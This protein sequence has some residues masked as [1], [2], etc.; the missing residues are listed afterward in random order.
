[1]TFTG[2]IKMA[3]GRIRSEERKGRKHKWTAAI[4]QH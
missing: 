2:R 3:E 1:M 4:F